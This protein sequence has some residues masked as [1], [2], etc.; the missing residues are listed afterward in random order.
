MKLR[1]MPFW[2]VRPSEVSSVA[3]LAEIDIVALARV[4]LSASV[5]VRPASTTVAL[6]P[7]VNASAL[8]V[9][10]TDRG[11]FVS[12]TGVDRGAG[13]IMKETALGRTEEACVYDKEIALQ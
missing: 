2:W 5:T 8:P 13:R 6:L 3:K 9:I 1:E 7:S 12:A 4:G 10:A 11:S